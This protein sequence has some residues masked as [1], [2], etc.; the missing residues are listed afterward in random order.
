M[1]VSIASG[2]GGTG[3]TTVAVNLALSLKDV[4]LLDCDVEEPNV[5]LLLKPRISEAKPVYV[6]IPKI[7]AELCNNCGKCAEFCEYNALFVSPEKVLVFPELCHSCGGCVI[8]CPTHAI[9]EEKRQIGSIKMGSASDIEVVYGE[10]EVGEP[11]PGPVIKE[12]KK[13]IRRDKTVI[14]DSPPGT[15]CSV[16]ESVYKSDYCLLVAESTPFGLHDLKIMVEV[17]SEIEIPFGIVINRAGLGDREIY[18]YCKDKSI[19]ILLE[20]PFRRRIAELYSR[21]VPFISEMP[22]WTEEFQ[23]LLKEIEMLVKS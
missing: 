4:Q 7:K 11:M 19:P 13:Q 17:L 23:T 2:K 10:L 15:S 6:T 1:I 3:K 5:H 14:I 20:I 21:G 16:I 18:K 8:V 22:E 9:A 12:V